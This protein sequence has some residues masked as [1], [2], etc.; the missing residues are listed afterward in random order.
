MSHTLYLL[1]GVCYGVD[2]LSAIG[3]LGSDEVQSRNCLHQELFQLM[4]G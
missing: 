3:L 4:E 2:V 1:S